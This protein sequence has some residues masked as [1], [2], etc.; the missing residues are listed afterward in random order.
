MSEIVAA[1]RAVA[2]WPFGNLSTP[3]LYQA[4][5]ADHTR[6]REALARHPRPRVTCDEAR[7]VVRAA[8][9]LA[10]HSGSN[11]FGVAYYERKAAQAQLRGALDVYDRLAVAS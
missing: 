2:W 8:R 1:A 9:L 5:C 3:A 7:F 4:R 11:R 6:L 10:E